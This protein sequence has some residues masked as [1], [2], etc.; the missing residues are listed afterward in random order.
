MMKGYTRTVSVQKQLFALH[1][2]IHW[3][4]FLCDPPCRLRVSEVITLDLFTFGYVKGRFQRRPLVFL[5]ACHSAGGQAPRRMIFKLPQVFIQ[6]GV[7]AVV[8]TACPV[9]ELFA[10]AFAR[11]FYDLF[12]KPCLTLAEALCLMRCYFW[13]KHHNPLG[14]ASGLYSPAHYRLAKGRVFGKG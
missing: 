6:H 3:Q 9:P 11:G 2:F 4:G 1:I 10:V 7:A 5:N 13:E 8:A 14:L 12:L